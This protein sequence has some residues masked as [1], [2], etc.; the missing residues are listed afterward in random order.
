MGWLVT[1]PPRSPRQFET[2][3]VSPAAYDEK[4]AKRAMILHQDTLSDA[5]SG[6]AFVDQQPSEWA[7]VKVRATCNAC[8]CVS[9][10]CGLTCM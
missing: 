9:V 4:G 8:A 3:L 10:V 1:Q 7:W 6:F 2:R 5:V